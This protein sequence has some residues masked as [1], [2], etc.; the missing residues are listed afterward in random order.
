M[1]TMTRIVPARKGPVLALEKGPQFVGGAPAVEQL[2]GA[3]EDAV[4]GGRDGVPLQLALEAEA[5]LDHGLDPAHVGEPLDAV[6][7]SDA[8]LL[9]A[10]ERQ[11]AHAVADQAVGVANVARLQLG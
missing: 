10:S 1:R 9:G 2:G 8:G 11:A 5:I 4:P 6:G 7:P 3:L